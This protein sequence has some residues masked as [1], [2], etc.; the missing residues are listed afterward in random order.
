M[1]HVG[2][3]EPCPC[4]SGRK[5]KHCCLNRRR[6]LLTSRLLVVALIG[7]AG[8][9][10]LAYWN[11][12][13][14]PDASRSDRVVRSGTP[15]WSPDGSKI[16]FYSDRDGNGEIYLVNADGSDPTRLTNHPADEG[17]PTFSPDGSKIAFDTDRDGNFDIYVMN[18]DGSDPR[19]LTNDPARDVSAS[20]SPDGSRIAFMSDRDGGFEI[21][22][23]DA[24]GSNLERLTDSGSNWFPRF[25]PDGTR[26]AFHVGRDVNVMNLD[27][28]GLAELTTDPD[29]GMYPSWSPDSKKIAFMSWRDGQTEIYMMNADGSDQKRLTRTTTGAVI[30]PRLSPD[31]SKIVYV[32]V[33]AGMA[34]GTQ[35]IYVMDA[36]GSN[37][38]RLTH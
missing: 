6:R 37:V 19:R 13:A 29:N 14:V 8:L 36:D 27:G 9:A 23:V 3:N 7:V 31:G 22:A 30:D 21:Y 28:T 1:A 24:D 32:D 20:W 25:S 26:L 38:K 16:V 4:G 10:A 34:E 12:R 5:F 33:P 35:I 15:S 2:R 18:A 17:Y 11:G